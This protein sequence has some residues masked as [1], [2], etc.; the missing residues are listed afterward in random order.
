[1]AGQT[2]EPETS[3]RPTDEI[4]REFEVKRPLYESL[5]ARIREELITAI[6]NAN[7]TIES[8]T[9]RTKSL[10]GFREKMTR[11]GK[12]YA[13]PLHEITDL[14]GVRVMAY[15]KS[16]IDAIGKLVRDLYTIDIANSIDFE[17]I[18]EANVF[19]YQSIHLIVSLN[20]GQNSPPELTGLKCE[21]QVRTILQHAWAETTHGRL[22]KPPTT[23]PK[24]V[25]RRFYAL[26]GLLEIAD[27]EFEFLRDREIQ[28]KLALRERMGK[29]DLVIEVDVISLPIYLAFKDLRTQKGEPISG[30][31]VYEL[32]EEAEAVGLTILRDVERLFTLFPRPKWRK[33]CDANGLSDRSGIGY[34]RDALKYHDPQAYYEYVRLARDDWDLPFVRELCDR[35]AGIKANDPSERD[36]SF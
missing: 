8:I 18:T 14:A 13:D 20:P 9:N 3:G 25:R 31:I 15:F 24:A 27:H 5:G 32:V 12:K 7:L 4:V 34:F 30:R 26:S 22:Y 6:R 29:G 17:T 1:M 23:P 10:E 19:G 11:P 28:V 2:R 36:G 35:I 21:V 16:D 33:F